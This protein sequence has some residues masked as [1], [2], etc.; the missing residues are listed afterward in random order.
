MPQESDHDMPSAFR[1]ERTSVKRPKP[2]TFTS[3]EATQ[4]RLFRGLDCLP[5]QLD[6]FNAD[7]TSGPTN[8]DSHGAAS[9][10]T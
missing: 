2:A 8:D 3:Q 7:K 5:G 4:L 1:L 9:R 10:R 6:L